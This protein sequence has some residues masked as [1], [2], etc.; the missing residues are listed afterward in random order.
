MGVVSCCLSEWFF[1]GGGIRCGGEALYGVNGFNTA[2][3]RLVAGWEFNI[4][5]EGAKT[6]RSFGF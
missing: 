6:P 4:K 3:P 2:T 5:S 1:L